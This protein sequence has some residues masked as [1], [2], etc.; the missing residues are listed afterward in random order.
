[1]RGRFW[2]LRDIPAAV[3]LVALVVAEFGN[4]R[5]EFGVGA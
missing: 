2:P 5:G 4:Q 3:W 1:M